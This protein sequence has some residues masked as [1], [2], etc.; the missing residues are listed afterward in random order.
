MKHQL[1]FTFVFCLGA[2]SAC[3][4]DT[5]TTPPVVEDAGSSSEVNSSTAETS[6]T[7]GAG[8]SSETSAT[9]SEATSSSPEGDAGDASVFTISSPN[10]DFGDPLP[11]AYT[12]QGKPFGDGYSPELNWSGAPAATKSYALVFKD[13]TLLPADLRGYHWGAWNIPVSVTGIPEHLG[14]GDQPE[15]LEGGSQFRAGPPHDNEFFGPCPSWNTFCSG[16]DPKTDQYAFTLYALDVEELE[17]PAPQEGVNY[18]SLL[19]QAFI[20]H[21]V[22][23][24]QLEATSDAVPTEFPFCPPTETD[25]GDAGPSSEPDAA[26]DSGTSVEST[27][28]ISGDASVSDASAGDAG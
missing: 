1:P 27:G 9:S 6:S 5:G 28:E 4:D 24:T 15:D 25:A 17:A 22:A 7:P 21:A 3:G 19:E 23:V 20:T 11:D 26:T 2:L 13:L 10:F 14:I 8:G 12:C 18:V 16:A